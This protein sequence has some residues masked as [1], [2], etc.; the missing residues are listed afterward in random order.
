MTTMVQQQTSTAPERAALIDHRG[1]VPLSDPNIGDEMRAAANRLLACGFVASEGGSSR[2]PNE[3]EARLVAYIATQ[4]GL[5]PLLGHVQLLGSKL[6]VGIAGLRRLMNRT[7]VVKSIEVRPANEQERKDARVEAADEYWICR[8][9][10]KNGLVRVGHGTA[11]DKDVPIAR[12][13][14]RIIRNLA[15]KRAE[16]RALVAALDVSFPDPEDA[17]YDADRAIGTQVTASASVVPA[18][19]Q[20][21]EVY[22]AK[23]AASAQPADRPAVEAA[24]V[25]KMQPVGYP[26]KPADAAPAAR[27]APAAAAKTKGSEPAPLPKGFEPPKTAPVA[28]AG[29]T[30]RDIAEARR[31]DA[32]EAEREARQRD[33]ERGD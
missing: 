4:Y 7:E 30:E 8:V 10:M 27:K 21:A 13:N 12:G 23:P 22:P 33:A 28:E 18:L 2:M 31:R 3:Y 11:N 5:D 16:Q 19:E 20:R 25:P 15:E 17:Q 29:M 6:Y 14:R 1:K 26:A 9:E 32:E 24:E